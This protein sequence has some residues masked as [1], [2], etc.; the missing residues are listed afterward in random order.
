MGARDGPLGLKHEERVSCPAADL[1]VDMTLMQ[2][3]RVSSLAGMVA[4]GLGLPAE[5]FQEAGRYG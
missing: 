3:D 2:R 4:V 5:A 1:V